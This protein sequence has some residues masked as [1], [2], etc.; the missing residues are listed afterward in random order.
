MPYLTASDLAVLLPVQ[1]GGS[2]LLTASSNP[3]MIDANVILG[4]VS[5]ELDAAA[6]KAGYTIPVG[7][8]ATGAFAQLAMYARWGAGYQVLQLMTQYGRESPALA[9]EYRSAYENA[10]EMLREGNVP[11]VGAGRDNTETSRSLPRSYYT[12]NPGSVVGPQITMDGSW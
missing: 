9:A 5:A 2:P 10:L 8:A 4:Q 7:T 12:S 1:S 11:L 6:A 3:N